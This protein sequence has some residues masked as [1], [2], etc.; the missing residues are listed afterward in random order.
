MRVLYLTEESI[1]FSGVLVRGG[2]IHVRNVV[3]GLRDR[4]HEVFLVDWNDD[5]ERPYQR[6]V[7]PATRFVDGPVRTARRAVA[8]AREEAVDVVVSKTRKTY[9]PGLVAARAVGVPHV[10]HVGTSPQPVDGAGT[11][12]RLD[13]LSF[14]LRLRAPH[15]GYLVVGDHIGGQLRSRGVPA[16]R[17]HDVKN[18]VDADAFD[19]D[20]VD[21]LPA[22]LRSK[23]PDAD[24]VVGF[25]GGLH[26]YK[27]VHDL[28]D[29]AE[30]AAADV[31]VAFAGDGPER[32]ALEERLADGPGALL[33]AVPYE[34]MP[35]LYAALDVFALPSHTEGI[36]RVILEAQAMCTPVVATRVGGVPDVVDDGETG[37]LCPPR[38]P[39]AL[40]DA[41]DRLADEP[42]LRRGL[43]SGG[44]RRVTESFTWPA[45]YDRYESGLRAIVS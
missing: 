4:G 31:A 11:I 28:V 21:P 1:T 34:A 2:A 10:V 22:E 42:E 30:A 12:D 7:Q 13:A 3:S 35:A 45:L 44:R 9:L 29:A 38:D 5:P 37:L 23:L 17:I 25:V 8:V 39:P 14:D 20:A 6:S 19:P 43:A 33:G 41:L 32:E 18:A 27:G 24:L 40:A 15:D 26:D 16:A 36:P